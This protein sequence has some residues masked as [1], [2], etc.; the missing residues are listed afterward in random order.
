[1]NIK[2]L[3]ICLEEEKDRADQ[4]RLMLDKMAIYSGILLAKLEEGGRSNIEKQF[5]A[6]FN[7]PVPNANAA[8]P[9]V[10]QKALDSQDETPTHV[11]IISNLAMEWVDFLAGFSCGSHVPFLAYGEDARKCVPEVFNFC[12]KMLDSEDALCSYL[13]AENEAFK[14]MET[15]RETQRARN[16]LLEQGI[17]VNNNSLGQC[18]TEGRL[19][20]VE[21]FFAAG[22]SPE[23]K[24]KTGV[25]LLNL[26]ARAGNLEIIQFLLKAGAPVNLRAEDR[27]TSALIDSVMGKFDDITTVLINAGADANIQSKDGQ[28]ALI[29]AVGAD[30]EGTVEVLLKAGANPDISDHMGMSARKYA[31]L[32]RKTVLVDLFNTYAPVKAG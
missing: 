21:L 4:L 19:D 25:P 31:S 24:D 3:I 15:D 29:V 12:F 32:F 17:P 18:V 14:K 22:F 6:F 9:P 5:F 20:D 1:M 11:M 10:N 13:N 7:L 26:A 2:L 23:T 8:A 30:E 16:T 27:D 28:T